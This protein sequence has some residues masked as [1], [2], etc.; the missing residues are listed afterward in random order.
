MSPVLLE[1]IT[2]LGDFTGFYLDKLK[3]KYPLVYFILAFFLL[4]SNSLFIFDMI[5]VSEDY[6]P[7]II[8]FL[9]GIGTYISPRTAKSVNNYTKRH[10][11]DNLKVTKNSVKPIQ[12]KHRRPRNKPDLQKHTDISNS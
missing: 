11:K 4:A 2:K 9:S 12:R 6:D 5:N 3:I 1:Y 8:L 10:E 7:I